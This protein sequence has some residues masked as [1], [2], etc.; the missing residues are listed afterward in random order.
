MSDH[1]LQ[2]TA[3]E[4]VEDQATIVEKEV[5]EVA[6]F[7]GDWLGRSREFLF[8][9][10]LTL[11]SLYQIGAVVAAFALA[12]VFRRA[13]RKLLDRIGRERALG[14]FVQRLI[15]TVSAISMPV[16]WA[17]GVWIGLTILET[18][19]LPT[20]LL[21][22]VGSLLNAFIVISIATIF[23]PNP[24]VSKAFAWIVWSIA[25]LNAIGLLDPVIEA[26]QVTGI[27]IG[28]TTI[29]LW[30]VVK[31]VF[32]S[33]LLVW[34]AYAAAEILQRQLE[35]SSS[36]NA[37]LRLLIAKIARI[38]LVVVA[39]VVGLTAVGV[40]LT[41]FAVFSG[42]LG[43]GVGLGMQRTIANLVA[44]FSLLADRSLKPGDVIEVETPQGPSYGVVGKMTTRYVSVRTRDGSETLVPNE[45]LISNPVTNWSY[46][47]KAVRR[48]IPIG[49]AYASDLDQVVALCLEAAAE[50]PRVIDDPKPACLFKG[51]GDSSIDLELRIWITDPENGVANVASD[52]QFRVW[53]KFRAHGVEVPFP[54]REVTLKDDGRSDGGEPV[55]RPRSAPPE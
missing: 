22:L 10:V 47:D 55:M 43:L 33:A 7:V 35:A 27:S 14:A 53:R 4:A 26:L 52:V 2:E 48:K 39:I 20:E 1:T 29:T 46:S 11:T 19:G 25:A 54:Q 18:F 13:F 6:S 45:V 41:A 30:T 37:A 16:C 24:R 8:E 23:I 31:G 15:R 42:A 17:I 3:A 40:D 5:E 36:L 44:S 21:R 12:L 49:V 28:E 38:A 50:S 51:F 9:N 34:L 32:L